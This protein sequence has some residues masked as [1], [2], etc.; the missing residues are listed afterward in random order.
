MQESAGSLHPDARG[1]DVV[2]EYPVASYCSS[3][4]AIWN[5]A[6]RICVAI[7]AVEATVD[8]V[9][10][11]RFPDIVFV[12]QTQ[13][14]SGEA[15]DVSDASNSS[16]QSRAYLNQLLLYIQSR[17][18]VSS[19]RKSR[20][21]ESKKE[22]SAAVEDLLNRGDITSCSNTSCRKTSALAGKYL[23]GRPLDRIQERYEFPY[24][25]DKI[26]ED[27]G[28]YLARDTRCR[29]IFVRICSFP[30]PSPSINTQAPSKSTFHP[31]VPDD[32]RPELPRWY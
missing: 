16:I 23:A 11:Q 21:K 17:A 3:A 2:E 18:T 30:P 22:Q 10:T 4:D 31:P 24:L 8:P 32:R 27:R 25:N 5:S 19:R 7:S 9:A 14:E 12:I 6:G 26:P 13:E 29:R 28:E 15:F 20:R 1:S